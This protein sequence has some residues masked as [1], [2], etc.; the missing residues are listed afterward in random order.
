MCCEPCKACN[1]DGKIPLEKAEARWEIIPAEELHLTWERD[2]DRKEIELA[3]KALEPKI[4]RF[5][6]L[7]KSQ[8]RSRPSRY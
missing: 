5:K 7:G 3:L 6:N 8:K 2:P 1:P 4:Q